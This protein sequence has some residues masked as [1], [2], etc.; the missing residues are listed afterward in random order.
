MKEIKLTQGKVAL[1]DDEDFERVNQ[2]KWYARKDSKSTTIFYAV[3]GAYKKCILLHRFIMDLNDS[4]KKVDHINHNGLDNRKNNLRACSSFE[5]ARNRNISMHSKTGFKGV[6]FLTVKGKYLA[7]IKINNKS[8]HIGLF[9]SPIE[10]A[11]AYNAKALEL[12]KEFAY[13]NKV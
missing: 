12:H 5:N 9:N 1:V 8:I 2:F 3:R 13:L 11:K 7:S 6:S 10:A 4:K